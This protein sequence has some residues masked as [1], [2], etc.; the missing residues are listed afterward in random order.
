MDGKLLEAGR[1]GNLQ[2]LYDAVGEDNSILQK[3]HSCGRLETPLHRASVFGQA[4]FVRE[5]MR[6]SSIS[7]HQLSQ[8][9][10]DGYSLLHLA[11]ANGHLEIV[12]C[13]LEFGKQNSF[14]EALCMK[15]EIDGRTA[16]HCAV[17]GGKV[18]VIDVLF[19]LCPQAA[20]EVTLQ[21]ETVLH[22]AVKHYQ[23]KALE[24]LIDQKLG[25]LVEGLLNIGDGTVEYLVKQPSLNVNAENLDGLRALDMLFSY[26]F[27]SKDVYIEKGIKNARGCRSQTETST[28]QSRPF[29]DTPNTPSG[30][31]METSAIQTGPS[32]G[33][34]NTPS[35]SQMETSTIQTRPSHDTPNTQSG[36]SS[37]AEDWLKELRSGIIIMASVFATLTFQVALTPP[38][39][40]W[41]DWGS[42]A[43]TMSNSSA[44][45]P[46]HQPGVP[47]LY[48]LDRK[49]FNLVMRLNTFTFM[50]SIATIIM[51]IQPFKM[52]SR[53]FIMVV[54]Y[55]VM[56]MVN[57]MFMAVEFFSIG[58]IMTKKRI[59]SRRV[60]SR[61]SLWFL[62]IAPAFYSL[63]IWTFR[64]SRRRRSSSS[65]NPTA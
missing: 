48:D 1:F 42:N 60:H 33:T 39:G 22:L 51:M 35:G 17:V 34:L 47:I 37:E 28:I 11:S 31:Q 49:Q 45:I 19:V 44:D 24:F 20:K 25:S 58:S 3:L 36:S 18:D 56:V 21:Q 54:L 55:V 57:V 9:N 8:L 52:K 13:L 46:A 53:A 5:Y 29:H 59:L 27:N 23:H 64:Y 50:A 41:Q 10:Q 4:E 15:T 16:L 65:R 43:T 63:Y 12:Q 26:P 62:I 38:G 2:A 61:N 40:V 30:S 7:A 14:V 32:H 6:L